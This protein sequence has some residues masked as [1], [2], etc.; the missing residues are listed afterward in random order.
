MDWINGFWF[1]ERLKTIGAL[2][3]TTSYALIA[4]IVGLMVGYWVP[5]ILFLRKDEEE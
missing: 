4:F 3:H 5:A 2:S 1:I